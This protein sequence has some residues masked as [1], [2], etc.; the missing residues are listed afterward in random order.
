MVYDRDR[1]G[2]S[3]PAQQVKLWERDGLLWEGELEL[4]LSGLGAIQSKWGSI[5]IIVDDGCFE[6][7]ED[8]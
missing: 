3:K 7:V 6:V 8:G 1:V 5:R 4:K 2:N